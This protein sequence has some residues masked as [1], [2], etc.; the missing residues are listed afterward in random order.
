VFVHLIAKIRGVLFWFFDRINGAIVIKSSIE[1][2]KYDQTDSL[3]NEM[4]EHQEKALKTM[5]AHTVQT[6][7]YY[8][9]NRKNTLKLTDFPVVDKTLIR[10]NQERFLSSVFNIN[11]LTAMVTSGST[12]IPFICYQDKEKKKRVSAEIIYYSG[13]VGYSVGKNLIIL[14]A[15]AGEGRKSTLRQWI[16]NVTVID[17]VNID[18]NHIE[19]LLAKISKISKNGSIILAYASTYDA[20]SDY[21][22]RRGLNNDCS[23]SGMISS[24]ELL[25]D[26]TRAIMEEAFKCKL[27]SRYSNQENGVIGQDYNENNVFIINEGHYIVEVLDFN[28]DKKVEEGKIGRIVVTDLYNYAMPMIRYDTGDIGSITTVEQNGIKKKAINNF[29]GR[30]IDLIFDSVGNPLSPHQISVTF[31][32]FSELKQFQFIQED[33]NKYLV[34]LKVDELFYRQD[35]LEVKLLRLL[36]DKAIINFEYV[37]VIPKLDSGKRNY[38]INKMSKG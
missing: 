24:S 5:L 3:S 2:T 17:V 32:F 20:L 27:V 6:V 30:K 14:Q 38:I 25:F 9:D 11:K 35:Q 16:E 21:L 22:K 33:N 23:I 7:D 12:G 15:F 18:D 19:K 28:I 36:G 10:E 26:D 37:E 34:R 4:T 1:V 31:R 29:S 8:R 13:K